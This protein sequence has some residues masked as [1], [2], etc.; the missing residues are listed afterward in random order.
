MYRHLCPV[1]GNGHKYMLVERDSVELRPELDTCDCTL[2]EEQEEDMAQAA[3][4]S[5][6]NVLE[7][8]L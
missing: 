4:Q 7:V 6:P 5:P 8:E 3:F 2:S 1:C